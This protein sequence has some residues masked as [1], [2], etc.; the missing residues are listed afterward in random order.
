MVIGGCR[1]YKI[2]QREEK[3]YLGKIV[4]SRKV[5]FLCEIC[6]SLM[7]KDTVLALDNLLLENYYQYL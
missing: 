1:Y 6:N 3:V 4:I 5:H 7:F 2:Y